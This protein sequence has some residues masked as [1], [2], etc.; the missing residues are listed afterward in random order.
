M[1]KNTLAIA[2]IAAIISASTIGFVQCHRPKPH[3]NYFSTPLLTEL[4]TKIPDSIIVAR[5]DSIFNEAVIRYES[6]KKRYSSTFTYENMTFQDKCLTPFLLEKKSAGEPFIKLPNG[7]ISLDSV[8]IKDKIPN[9]TTQ[10]FIRL[11]PISGWALDDIFKVHDDMKTFMMAS[12]TSFYY[13]GQVNLSKKFDSFVFINNKYT[14]D[15]YIKKDLY[16]INLSDSII[17]SVSQLYSFFNFEGTFY[18]HTYRISENK[19]RCISYRE[20]ICDFIV[21]GEEPPGPQ[22][23]EIFFSFDNQGRIVIK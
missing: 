15:E 8:K 9:E 2:A 23:E 12:D 18:T 10:V 11:Y 17:T 1:K 20:E 13:C 5:G 19:F 22:T 7:D 21:E 6:H 3:K 16:I 14:D 4:N